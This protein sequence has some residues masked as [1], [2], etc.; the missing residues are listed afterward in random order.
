M[1]VWKMETGR[2][3]YCQNWTRQTHDG[4]APEEEDKGNKE[5]KKV[6]GRKELREKSYVH[7]CVCAQGDYV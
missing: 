6:I 3:D 5:G 1:E 2:R 7:V 4:T